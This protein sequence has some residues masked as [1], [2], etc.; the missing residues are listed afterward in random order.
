M[1][2]SVQVERGTLSRVLR[3]A[4]GIWSGQRKPEDLESRLLRDPSPPLDC[5]VELAGPAKRWVHPCPAPR[6]PQR[7]LFSQV[8]PRRA[9]ARSPPRPGRT[10]REE[11]TVGT[12][13]R[14]GYGEWHCLLDLHPAAANRAAHIPGPRGAGA[15]QYSPPRPSLAARGAPGGEWGNHCPEAGL[16]GSPSASPRPDCSRGCWG[17]AGPWGT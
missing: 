10:H 7:T 14:G 4:L 9:G 2:P 6:A 3:A 15:S 8:A 12:P 1:K 16:P 13:E 17:Y 11:A 5:V